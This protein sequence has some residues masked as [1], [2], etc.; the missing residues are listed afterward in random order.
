M[1][2]VYSGLSLPMNSEILSYYEQIFS[3]LVRKEG[4]EL[5]GLSVLLSDCLAVLSVRCITLRDVENIEKGLFEPPQLELSYDLL[6][7]EKRSLESHPQDHFVEEKVT[8][9]FGIAENQ[10]DAILV[11]MKKYSGLD[12]DFQLRKF[13]D[14]NF[15]IKNEY[16]LLHSVRLH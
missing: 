10:R 5:E 7:W 6:E 14:P 4:V 13:F 1:N 12:R 16:T 15:G 11:H 3:E 9:E 8:Y 2:T